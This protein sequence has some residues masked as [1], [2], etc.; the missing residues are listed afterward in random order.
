MTT[1]LGLVQAAMGEMGLSVPTYVAGNSA[2]DIVQILALLNQSGNELQREHDWQKLSIEYR[3]TVQ[4]LTTTGTLTSGSTIVTAI[5][6]TSGLSALYGVTGTGINQDTY[7]SSV[8]STTQVTLNQAASSSGTGVS[9]TFGQMKYSMPSDYDRQIDRTHWDKSK[10]WQMLGPETA[11]QWQWLKSGYISTGPRIR[12]RLLDGYFQIWPLIATSEY[13]GFEYISKNW[14]SS[15]GVSQP[16]KASFTVDTDT[17]IYPDRLIINN[18]KRKYF[19]VKGFDASFFNSDY[20]RELS[21]AKANEAGSATL[22]FAPQG[23]ELLINW[24]NIPDSNFG[25]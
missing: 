16:D 4:Y 10:H 23:S 24:S 12:Y 2:A 19:A 6:T 22:S 17:C 8:D 3:F 7:I 20:Q 21:I 5:P 13:L 14:V 11:Q 18:L 1:M 15:T 9:L 25:L